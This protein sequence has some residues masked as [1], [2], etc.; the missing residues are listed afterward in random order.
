VLFFFG[1]VGGFSSMYLPLLPCGL[2]LRGLELVSFLSVLFWPFSVH[3]RDNIPLWGITFFLQCNPPLLFFWP[4]GLLFWS[5]VCS[6]VSFRGRFS[7]LPVFKPLGTVCPRTLLWCGVSLSLFSG[8]V[9]V[10]GSGRLALGRESRA[11]TVVQSSF[12]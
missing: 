7:V 10:G 11:F 9:N 12:S 2:K 5:A 4:V 8:K 3:R 1:F 6:A